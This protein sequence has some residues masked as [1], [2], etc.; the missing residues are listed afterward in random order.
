MQKTFVCKTSESEDGNASKMVCSAMA[1]P[2]SFQR[3]PSCKANCRRFSFAVF[4]DIDYTNP[5]ALGYLD[6]WEHI[7]AVNVIEAIN[8]DDDIKFTIGIGDY[9]I[10]DAK[11]EYTHDL[12]KS[13]IF[14]RFENPVIPTL[15]DNDWSEI[16]G[17]SIPPGILTQLD[18]LQYLRDS[19]FG[20]PYS[21][22]QNQFEVIRQDDYPE[23]QMFCYNRIVFA[24]FHTVGSLDKI[25]PTG[26]VPSISIIDAEYAARRDANLEWISATF[27]YARRINAKGIVFGTQA[28]HWDRGAPAPPL[29]NFYNGYVTGFKTRPVNSTTSNFKAY[30][31]L[32]QQEALNFGDVTFEDVV[33]NGVVRP[34]PIGGKSVLLVYGDSHRFTMD[35]PMVYPIGGWT[36]N[37]AINVLDVFTSWDMPNYMEVQTTGFP[38]QGYTKINVDL[39]SPQIFSVERGVTVS[40]VKNY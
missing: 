27:D 16:N 4:G 5:L 9:G 23:N 21:L 35:T 6:T 18:S 33:V 40:T 36:G 8:N 28:D 10:S 29:G 13:E 34:R 24:T 30:Y 7:Q 26:G 3:K 37:P 12:K 19:W 14:D 22:G 38:R 31:E 25:R 2:Q 32:M 11:T 20:T 17:S 15:G 39:K 1:A